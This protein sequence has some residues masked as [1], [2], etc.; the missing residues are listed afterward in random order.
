MALLLIVGVGIF[1][2]SKGIV[3]KSYSAKSVVEKK[4]EVNRDTPEDTE[5]VY[6]DETE[7]EEPEFNKEF[8]DINE[9]TNEGKVSQLYDT[10]DVDNR[11]L[12]FLG[13]DNYN[14]LSSVLEKCKSGGFDWSD[15][16]QVKLESPGSDIV[17]YTLGQDDYLDLTE[18]MS[19]DM[20]TF[21][22]DLTIVG[23][24]DNTKVVYVYNYPNGLNDRIVFFID[25]SNTDFSL[26]TVKGW[27][28]GD[29]RSESIIPSL[30]KVVDVGEFRVVMTRG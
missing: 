18:V 8:T 9:E 7:E 13:K 15:V 28:F 29:V 4:N 23:L 25:Y 24:Y 10:N 17:S 16:P 14:E 20:V 22:N 6:E 21:N 5:K 30:C 11:Q 1:F 12:N 3:N 19:H 27:D 26:D 2:L